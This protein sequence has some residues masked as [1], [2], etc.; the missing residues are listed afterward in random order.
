MTDDRAKRV[1]MIAEQ[2]RQ[3]VSEIVRLGLRIDHFKIGDTLVPVVVDPQASTTK[4]V[5]G[6]DVAA[7]DENS[8]LRSTRPSIESD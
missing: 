7:L 2:Y 8:N 6:D 5:S 4:L 1:A 3:V